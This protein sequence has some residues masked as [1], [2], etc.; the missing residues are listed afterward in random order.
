MYSLGGFMLCKDIEI[1]PG[2]HVRIQA[3]RKGL[4]KP[5]SS[6]WDSCWVETLISHVGLRL[7]LEIKAM[8]CG[9]YILREP[10]A[11]IQ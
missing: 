10:Q 5:A 7:M 3:T 6:T 11:T 8:L 4:Q 1:V 9:G 2:N